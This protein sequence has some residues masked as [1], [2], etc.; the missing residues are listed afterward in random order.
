MSSLWDRPGNGSS[1]GDLAVS[2]EPAL[3]SSVSLQGIRVSLSLGDLLTDKVTSAVSDLIE[4]QVSFAPANPCIFPKQLAAWCLLQPLY[5]L[6]TFSAAPW[7]WTGWASR[8]WRR[9]WKFWSY[10]CSVVFGPTQETDQQGAVCTWRKSRVNKAKTQ[11]KNS[12]Y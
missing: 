5:I 1:K 3:W 7:S 9:K 12:K 8:G 2:R 11:W 10:S 6:G 4:P